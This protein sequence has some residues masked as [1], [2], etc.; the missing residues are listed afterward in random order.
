MGDWDR[1]VRSDLV[2]SDLANR[3]VSRTII[4]ARRGL[5]FLLWAPDLL[6]R[7]VKLDLPVK[8]ASI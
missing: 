6:R 7:A 5:R 4:T 1:R 3:P 8:E 2:F